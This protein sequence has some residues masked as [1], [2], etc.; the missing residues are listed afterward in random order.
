[1][2]SSPAQQLIE[3]IK[4]HCADER[5]KIVELNSQLGP[6]LQTQLREA[7]SK[8]D[9]VEKLFLDPQILAEDRDPN[10]WTRWLD[11]ANKAFSL[12]VSY[13][14][15]VGKLRDKYGSDAKAF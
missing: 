4:K 3:K 2:V 8:L 13:R 15:R 9:E 6:H 10:Q 11:E 1:M 14:E 7:S 5:Q 12:A